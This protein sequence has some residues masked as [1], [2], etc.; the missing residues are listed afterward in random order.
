MLCGKIAAGKS[1]LARQLAENS[2]AVLL[3]EDVWLHGLFA[4]QMTTGQD[5]L[6]CAQKLRVVMGPHVV[7]L[8]NAGLS[9]VLDFPANTRDSRAWMRGL[10]GETSAQGVMHLLEASDALCLERLKTRNST[11]AH[12][13]AVTETQFHRFSAYFD[14]P[15]AE[16]GFEIIWHP[17][18]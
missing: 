8:L 1:T 13:F 12:P 7:A 5:Y 18:G 3:S 2:G 11:G 14:P 15:A 16:E 4:D 6:R 9:V 17:V 10:L